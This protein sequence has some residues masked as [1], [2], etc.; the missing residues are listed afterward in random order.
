M[1]DEFPSLT[2]A[3]HRDS[4]LS[5]DE[6]DAAA[7]ADDLFL[8][9]V[10]AGRA[11]DDAA[12]VQARVR[13]ACDAIDAPIGRIEPATPAR[14]RRW[15]PLVAAAVV[16]AAVGLL[17]MLVALPSPAYA[18]VDASLERLESA[19]LTF[20]I[21]VESPNGE[22]DATGRASGLQR[23]FDGATLHVRGPQIVL[24]ANGRN[25]EVFVRGHDGERFWSNHLPEDV[26]SAISARADR[27]IP[28]QRF[29]DSIDGDLRGLLGG[30][31]RGYVLTSGEAETDPHD[32]AVLR[33]FSGTRRPASLDQPDRPAPGER[34]RGRHGGQGERFGGDN[35]RFGGRNGRFGGDNERFGG[36]HERF[37]CHAEQFDIWIDEDG[38]LRRLRLSGMPGRDGDSIGDLLLELIDTAPLDDAVFDPATYPEIERSQMRRDGNMSRPPRGDQPRECPES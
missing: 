8:D 22:E 15:R 2:G 17:T 10:L 11:T 4:I 26:E 27:G 6:V 28:F 25:G 33:R 36:R 24:L 34:M 31:R 14:G 5:A 19:D 13:A 7:L 3:D 20:R 23:R 30:L 1:T 18:T 9:A 16:V 12:S 35:E 29:L 37:D 21:S 38:N 32:G